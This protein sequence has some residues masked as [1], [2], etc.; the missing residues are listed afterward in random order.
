[1][2]E[3][4]SFQSP[5]TTLPTRR[6]G[7]S[8]LEVSTVGLGCNNFGGRLGLEETRAVLDE[9]LAAG[10][11]LFDTADI[12]G[13]GGGSEALMGEV[14]EGRRDEFVLATKF[15]MEMRGA[16]AASA[17]AAA[18]GSREYI[19]WAVEGSLRRLRSDRIDLYQYHEPDGVTPIAETLAALGELVA[20]G[21][22]AAIGCSNFSA[23]ELEQ[24]DRV[25]RAEGLP[26]FV[27]LQNHYSLLEREIEAEVAPACERLG[28]SILPFFPLE[29]GLLTGKYRRG[30]AG[31][32]GTRLAGS[33]PGTDAQFDVVEAIEAFAAER[34]IEP[35][36]VAIAGLA[37]QPAVAS[38]IAGATKAE[39]VRANVATLR[40][41][42]SAED[43]AELD[44][45]APTPRG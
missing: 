18:R 5:T 6:L 40:W 3:E 1:M 12:Y 19:R 2:E 10:I 30:Q 24:A 11:T 7:D 32:E 45:I 23:A 15:G 20:E 9:A 28:V 14:L 27:T 13:G 26:R 39:Q 29:R 37:A 43:L 33:T 8:P 44:R 25:A 41:T 38:V 22:V 34:G 4:M 21:T 17:P 31:P 36:D 42:P 16:E 35:I